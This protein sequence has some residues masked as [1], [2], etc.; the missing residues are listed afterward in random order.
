MSLKLLHS[1]ALC[2]LLKLTCARTILCNFFLNTQKM[3]ILWSKI[4]VKLLVSTRDISFL[5][6]WKP[7]SLQWQKATYVYFRAKLFPFW[8]LRFVLCVHEKSGE[9][10][11]FDGFENSLAAYVLLSWF[12]FLNMPVFK[13]KGM[14][15]PTHD[16]RG[17]RISWESPKSREYSNSPVVWHL[18]EIRMLPISMNNQ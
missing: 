11:H 9:E 3:H 6:I 4:Y 17:R 14:S 16:V 7:T 10:Q 12:C 5:S 18:R 1:H 8:S 13:Y 2:F 15:S